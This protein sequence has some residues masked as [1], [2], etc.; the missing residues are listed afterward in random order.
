V[1]KPSWADPRLALGAVLVLGSVLLGARLVGSA[2]RTYPAV[3][4]AHD[5]QRGTVLS[6]ADLRIVRVRLPEQGRGR[7]PGQL[8]ALIGKRLDRPIGRGELVPSSALATP[9]TLTTLTVPLSADAAPTLHPGDRI[10]VWLAGKTCAPVRVVADITVQRV[11]VAAGGSFSVSGGQDVVVSVP[12]DLA[13][14]L[15]VALSRDGAQL[16]AGVLSG[17]RSPDESDAQPSLDCSEAGSGP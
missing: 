9:S 2:D 15:V 7:Y 8:T 3:A 13:E 17:P 16:R 6:A 5:G 4:M 11:H 14:R 10:A 12:P 1:A